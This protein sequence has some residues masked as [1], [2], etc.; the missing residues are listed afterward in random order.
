MNYPLISEYV[1]AIKLAEDNLDQLS[2][3]R[4]VLDDEGQPVMS[5]GNF[6]V[7]FKMKDE[8][9][10]KFYA[11]KCFLREQEGRAECY[12]LISEELRK[13]VSPYILSADYLNNELF[14][15]TNQSD[16]TD[17]PVLIMEWVEGETLS[18]FL[19]SMATAYEAS[20]VWSQ[21]EE[22]LA[23]YEL[24]C[25]PTNFIRMASWLIKQPFAHGDVKPDNIIIK[26][27]GTC[28]LVDYDGMYVPSMQGMKQHY[29]GTPNYMHPLKTNQ[30]RCKEID[31]YA[32]SIIALSLY[33]FALKPEIISTS[34]D[35][36]V[37][38]GEEAYTLH[39]IGL[40]KDEVLMSDSAFRELLSIYLHTLSQNT[41][42]SDYYD[43]CVSNILCP[44]D[45]NVLLTEAT[46]DE[47]QHAWTDRYGVK[48]SLDGRKV[49]SASEKLTDV[50]YIIREGVIT[51]C[52]QAFQ[53]KGLKSIRL[54]NSVIAIG[55][56][57][58]ANNDYME[59][60]NIPS[61]VKFICDNNPWG[62][63][64]NIKKMDCD[65]PLYQ[66]KD[67]I[68]Y[69]LD[70]S[71]A[72]GFIYRSPEVCID[73]KT[74]AIAANA[75][76][77][78]RNGHDS[79]IKKI[80]LANVTEVGKA[81][82]ELCK[83]ACFEI[84]RP[85]KEL[86][87]D[88]FNGCECLEAIN[89]SEAR[90]IPE[91]VFKNCK[92]LAK[93]TLS[94]KLN[95]INSDSFKGCLSLEKIDIPKTVS[96]ISEDAFKECTALFEINVDSDNKY[97]CTVDGV[98]YNKSITKLIKLPPGKH[99]K[100]FMIPDTIYEIGNGAFESC[101]FLET[102]KCSNKILTFGTDV[103][104]DC[105]KLKSCNIYLDERTDSKSAWNLGS[106]LFSL[107]NVAEDIKQ[108]GYNLISMAAEKNHSD[109]QWFLARSFKYGWNGEV[110]KEK[111]IKWLKR[112]AAN[113]QYMA[114][115]R[116]AREFLKGKLIP[117]DYKQAYEILCALKDAGTEAES[118]CKGD[119]FT[120]LGLCFEYGLGVAKNEKKAVK[121][122]K[123]GMLWGNSIAEFALARCYEKGI[124]LS[125][126][127]QKAKEY[128][129]KAKRHNNSKAD[130]ALKRVETKI[131][132][133]YDD[134]PF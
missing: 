45:Y 97:Y 98:L 101:S 40:L 130:E 68:L 67:G 113:K 95:S 86:G 43:R 38:S 115:S 74:K 61:S 89:I 6:A 79:Y 96:Y 19:S 132:Q 48:Y 15:N 84:K 60:C 119:F 124:G 2:Y 1:E 117:N 116:L 25:L 122:Y 71:I 91:E 57:A 88:S 26:P 52:D 23:F 131:N 7:V 4:P 103:F 37:I 90:I 93:V 75:F 128:Y 44:R 24:R 100:D 104:N 85:I 110:N 47:M 32:I 114:M 82:F 134:L 18:S 62:G 35:Y 10:G 11:M 39:K 55:V 107:E 77:S 51:I 27:D 129:L 125:I 13:T 72:Y 63:C 121:Y 42:T 81:A 36:C 70:F 22:N 133:D 111:Y 28:V 50:D 58:F 83:S 65:S 127:L 87:E 16:L 8:R 56:L 108:N 120:E 109:A 92:N 80:L 41:L 30:I 73:F 59:Y 12:S 66:I 94:S 29:F 106:F 123:K 21:E 105:K 14:V 112:S 5:S 31:D 76:W 53:S 102:I 64:F 49:I 126:N 46:E 17:F 69:S 118:V 34:K 20:D 9:N 3:L 99:I 78:S 33:A 54:P